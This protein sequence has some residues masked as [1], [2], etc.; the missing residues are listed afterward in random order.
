MFDPGTLFSTAAGSL[1]AMMG[2]GGRTSVST[3]TQTQVGTSLNINPTIANMIGGSGSVSPQ[4]SGSAASSP[5]LSGSATASQAADQSW[6]Y[7]SLLNPRPVQT[8]RP[9]IDATGR[10]GAGNAVLAGYAGDDGFMWLLLI[11]GAA[12]LFFMNDSN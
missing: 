4:T 7:S 3:N 9:A 1:P 5:Y 6:P 10:V 8:S 12:L 11:G 2:G